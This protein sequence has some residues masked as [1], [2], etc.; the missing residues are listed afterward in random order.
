[1]NQEKW[2][3]LIGR[4]QDEFAVLEHATEDGDIDGE[5]VESLIFVN[6]AGKMMLERSVRPRLLE[7]KTH[8]SGRLSGETG[9]EKI[10]SDTET[11]DAV[12]LFRENEAGEWVEMD[13]GALG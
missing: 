2:E 1:M 7:E 8:Y 5:K 3:Q 4:I 11:V 13:A 10:Y 6:P 12:K 9:I